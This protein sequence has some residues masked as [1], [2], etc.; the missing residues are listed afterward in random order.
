[1]S[2]QVIARKELK[3]AI[4]SRVLHALSGILVLLALA[5]TGLYVSVPTLFGAPSSELTLQSFIVLLGPAT[6]LVPI[7]GAMLGY[8]A[9]A[10]ERE[11]GSLNLMLSQ[12]HTRDD[13]VL[14][15]FAGR[16]VVLAIPVLLAFA[17]GLV[18]V[19]LSFDAYSIVDYATFLALLVLI[20]MV[21]VA[22]ATSLSASTRSTT[23]AAVGVLAYY[24]VFKM[25]W[26]P[27]MAAIYAVSTRLRT[28]EWTLQFG[29]VPDWIH[30]LRTLSPHRAYQILLNELI[31]TD[32]P[33]ALIEQPAFVN[34]WTAIVVLAL[35]IVGP[36]TLG[37]W[38]FDAVD[39]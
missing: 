5:L 29:G 17:A 38:R 23:K 15:K 13:V 10:G 21:Y 2:W 36:L 24:V 32:S 3:D 18:V 12:P 33:G 35:W 39:L 11:T 26:A 28:G 30:F 16:S 25:V 4:R 22:V 31:L 14:G 1:M 34:E 37:L 9:I 19:L 7:L 20:G 8:K 6:A 27:L